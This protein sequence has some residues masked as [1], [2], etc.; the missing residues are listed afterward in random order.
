MTPPRP[1]GE[2]P[3]EETRAW[4]LDALDSLAAAR[5][6]RLRE[7]GDSRFGSVYMVVVAVVMGVAMGSAVFGEA[8]GG[9]LCR[10]E[11]CLRV[12]DGPATA[13]LAFAAA[14]V[15]L[16]GVGVLAAFLGPV[17]LSPARATWLGATP[18]DRAVLLRD[19]LAAVVLCAAGVGLVGGIGAA[20][21]AT[22]AS[23][24]PTAVGGAVLGAA[25]GAG[26][27][28][29]AALA[30]PS[31]VGVRRLRVLSWGCVAAGLVVA[32]LA[33]AL[34]QL[35]GLPVGAV[36]PGLALIGVAVVVAG[37]A[38]LV[39]LPRAL[40]LFTTATL[41]R[42][43]EALEATTSSILMLDGTAVTQLGEARARASSG[44][45]A[46]RRL[47]GRGEA[48]IIAAEVRRLLRAPRIAVASLL[49]LPVPILLGALFGTGAGLI[50]AALVAV[51]LATR[52][53]SGLRLWTRSSGLARWFPQ[54]PI[55]LR[56]A[57]V[58]AP[59]ALAGLWLA[60]VVPAVGLGALTWGSLTVAAA[61][62][63]LRSAGESHTGLAAA[64][65]SMTPMGAVPVGLMAVLVRGPDIAAPT[66]ALL[67]FGLDLPAL[68]IAIVVF[69]WALTRDST[70]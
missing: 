68:I 39:L 7:R 30:Q 5:G 31:L 35:P 36:V 52:A 56:V 51:L 47:R 18:A 1:Q 6:E 14:A 3:P 46:S 21:A 48:A 4:A 49:A 42:S 60:L 27:S 15:T 38:A 65:T 50:G 44:R 40:P 16:G 32:G 2:L 33:A 23:S 24:V 63:A 17:G 64:N 70:D 12:T 66:V 13:W 26:A 58:A 61:A 43:G 55:R 22:A 54:S 45:Y 62:A 67:L 59:T 25:A 69:G 57:Y 20:L 9:S 11:A 10:T 53:A 41:R 8:I 29:I 19:P 34:P 28:L 37:L